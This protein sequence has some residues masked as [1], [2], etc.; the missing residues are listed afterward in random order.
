[1]KNSEFAPE[2]TLIFLQRVLRQDAGFECVAVHT[3]RSISFPAAEKIMQ[4][5]C[6]SKAWLRGTLRI[7]EGKL[8]TVKF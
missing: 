3:L 7:K 5:F 6:M 8:K 4:R 1:M 2:D